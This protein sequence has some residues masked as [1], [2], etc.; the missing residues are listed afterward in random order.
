ME[1]T[2]KLPISEEDWKNLNAIWS[3]QNSEKEI[4]KR[5]GLIDN[6]LKL[7]T[8]FSSERHKL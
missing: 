1:I 8:E 3:A 2:I 4:E 7:G 6:F 5:K